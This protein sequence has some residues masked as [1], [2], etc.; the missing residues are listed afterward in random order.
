MGSESEKEAERE[1][2]REEVLLV[3]GKKKI[4]DESR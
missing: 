4:W 2:E 1:R 3:G